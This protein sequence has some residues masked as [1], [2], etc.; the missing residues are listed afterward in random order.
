[1]V[2]AQQLDKPDNRISRPA[3]TK[4]RVTYLVPRLSQRQAFGLVKVNGSTSFPLSVGRFI[5]S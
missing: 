2:A 3:A 1:V 4:R 5:G